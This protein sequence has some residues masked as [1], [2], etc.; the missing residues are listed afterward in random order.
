MYNTA[1]TLIFQLI[2]M[3]FKHTINNFFHDGITAEPTFLIKHLLVSHL[4]LAFLPTKA[5]SLVDVNTGRISATVKQDTSG[6]LSSYFWN[7]Q[8]IESYK[9]ESTKKQTNKLKPKRKHMRKYSL[10]G[11]PLQQELRAKN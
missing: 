10:A 3:L 5:G 7:I 4:L 1:Q 9:A 11:W 2:A 6:I 8:N